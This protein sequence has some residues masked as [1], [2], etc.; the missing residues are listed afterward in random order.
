MRE[1]D[2]RV[3]EV[4]REDISRV[5]KVGEKREPSFLEEKRERNGEEPEAKE[6]WNGAAPASLDPK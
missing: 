4:S 5:K 3:D 6:Q 1:S 2:E